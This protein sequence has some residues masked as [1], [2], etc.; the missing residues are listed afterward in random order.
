MNKHSILAVVALGMFSVGVTS[1]EDM[2][3]SFW[4]KSPA[5]R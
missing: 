5:I 3:G 4:T 1:C 2:F